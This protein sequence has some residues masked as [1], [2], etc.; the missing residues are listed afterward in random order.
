M[1]PA[2]S[3]QQNIS[4]AHAAKLMNCGLSSGL[5][6]AF[7]FNPWDRALYLSVK[8]ER[9]FLRMDNFRNPMAGVFQ[10]VLQR[11][12]S[13]GLYFPIE[14]LTLE[15]LTFCVGSRNAAITFAAGTLAGVANGVIMN[16]FTRIKVR[17]F[18]CLN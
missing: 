13:S 14:E 18:V 15:L 16:P 9:P 7:I 11:A 8:Y 4:A 10:T 12:I 3:Q 2:G 5:I 6:Q 1:S 17:S